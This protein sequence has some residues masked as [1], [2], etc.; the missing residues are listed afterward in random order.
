MEMKIIINNQLND[1]LNTKVSE[2]LQDDNFFELTLLKQDVVANKSGIFVNY[3][4]YM[5]ESLY[6]FP[7][8]SLQVNGDYNSD[9]FGKVVNFECEFCSPFKYLCAHLVAL[10][11]QINAHYFS[12]VLYD[13]ELIAK[14]KEKE[15]E[16][17]QL[18]KKNL[19]IEA[20]QKLD[21]LVTN[22][23]K[24]E[25]VTMNQK[26]YLEPIIK[27]EPN[28][29]E[30]G[31]KMGPAK[32]FVIKDIDKFLTAIS[33]KEVIEYSKSFSTDHNINSFDERSKKL[34]ELLMLNGSLKYNKYNKYI[35]ITKV[36][37]DKLMDLYNGSNITINYEGKSLSYLVTNELYHIQMQIKNNMLLFK[38]LDL[39]F[40]IE[41]E[42]Y[43]YIGHKGIIE[44]IDESEE[45]KQLQLFLLKE[46]KFDFSL[47]KD[48]FVKE[49]YSRFSDY[50]LADPKFK[51]ENPLKELEIKAY[52][53]YV[54]DKIILDTK[55]F[56]NKQ[57][58]SYDEA[59]SIA[60]TSKKIIKYNSIIENIGF[61]NNEL[62]TLDK[63]TAFLKADLS[64]LK[65]YASIY[66]SNSLSKVQVKKFTKPIAKLSY[67]LGMLDI[68]FDNLQYS[69][70]ELQKIISGIKKKSKYIE[71]KD[72]TILELDTIDSNQFLKTIEEFHLDTK[73]LQ[74]A[75]TKPLYQSLKIIGEKDDLVKVETDAFL[76]TMIDDIKNY[77]QS[78]FEVDD[79]LK[80][81]M[82]DY[83]IEAYKWIKTLI[84]Y[85]FSG[86]IA[87]DMG[88]GKTLEMISVIKEDSV[89]MPS[90]IVCPKSLIYN[91][92]NEFKKW[93]P[94]NS[95]EAIDLT[96]NNRKNIISKI[97]NDKKVIYV[98]SYD[99][100]RN[101]LEL[102]QDKKFK[103][104]ILDEAQYIKN[105]NTLK[106]Q[107][108]K[109]ISSLNRFVLTGTPIENSVMD[110]WSIFD[111][112]M[113]SYLYNYNEFKST[114]ER[115]IIEKDEATIK[116]LI[117]KI[118][119]FVLRRT[120]EDVLKSLPGKVNKVFYAKMQGEQR[121][122][123]EA[124]LL[125][126]REAL[127][128][129]QS[130]I[131]ILA[132]LTRLRQICVDPAL[133]IANYNGESCKYELLRELIEEYVSDGHKILIFSQFT[134]S[135][136]YIKNMLEAINIPYYM[137]TGKTKADARVSMAT[138][139]NENSDEKVFLCSLKAGGTGLNLVGADIVIHLDPWWN[140]A[141]E[142][143]AT[144]RA[145]RIGQ[146]NIVQVIKII[147]Q[148][149]IEQ[150]VVELQEIKK[151]IANMLISSN[152]ENIVKL[153]EKDL[154]Y[155]LS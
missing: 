23:K 63:V 30:L 16:Y 147:C 99:S 84:K 40:L 61:I 31:L 58:V 66:L 91:W 96:S 29:T 103:F 149:S 82:R 139:F 89:D 98:T 87:D 137:L 6:K 136:T 141:A 18:E 114:Y 107:S 134:S 1:Y 56:L 51:E 106:A 38:D 45:I 76:K 148:D 32:K 140:S 22:I 112:L 64:E 81:V 155:I 143:Q 33:N 59:S 36:F 145:H 97:K 132:S 75:Q 14:I 10:I 150:K 50:I 26:L 109:Q 60:N 153:D 28:Y 19:S 131:E 20:L 128:S 94:E 57:E 115:N 108:V 47:I 142:N 46:Q 146:K 120:K 105:H 34:I 113:P 104:M 111:F 85:N 125:K 62:V 101:D 68:A 24:T 35:E 138:S 15:T 17:K 72:N 8:M 52:F 65:K 93:S 144:D 122:V 12:D 100:L 118:T 41:G 79:S 48:N 53:D 121:K 126:T 42:K 78:E 55:Y 117:K 71:L 123:Y 116:K 130:K 37:Y 21:C 80:P 135:F 54:N 73:K 25:K 70:E 74:E 13:D 5:T 95:V 4:L 27:I 3:N 102:Y 90:L 44:V 119:P 67:N 2:E 124:E 88:L 129:N 11:N 86:I 43:N 92:V 152:D 9:S 110:L 7:I 133:Y 154:K 83:Q 77:K 151:D 127:K 69:E 39:D 49:I